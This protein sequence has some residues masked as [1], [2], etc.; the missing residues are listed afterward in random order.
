MA[1]GEYE[2]IYSYITS[3]LESGKAELSWPDE[4]ST[5][6]EEG[7]YSLLLSNSEYSADCAKQLIKNLSQIKHSGRID[8]DLWKQIIETNSTVSV[9]LH[10]FLLTS[11]LEDPVSYSSID[12]EITE[13]I[14]RD[15]LFF[16][17]VKTKFT[18]TAILTIQ[19]TDL[20]HKLAELGNL[21]EALAIT[22]SIKELHKKDFELD[23]RQSVVQQN[24]GISEYRSQLSIIQ[25]KIDRL[26]DSN[27]GIIS[28]FGSAYIYRGYMVALID[29][30]VV[31]YKTHDVYE[32]RS[33]QGITSMLVTKETGFRTKGTFSLRVAKAAEIPM[34]LKE[35]F[36]GF[37]QSIPLLVEV[38]D[39]EW[40]D[41]LVHKKEHDELASQR[42]RLQ[43]LIDNAENSNESSVK[44]INSQRNEIAR[45]IN[46]LEKNLKAW[47]KANA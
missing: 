22:N 9:G 15:S 41:Y 10:K 45:E 36:G 17:F 31:K 20:I 25:G 29:E 43:R 27:N 28:D 13:V 24:S 46:K 40:S 44:A 8:N 14:K 5:S 7:L 18:R 16:P 3:E 19:K 38:T 32:V 12:N 23:Q 2:K 1:D 21:Q 26:L 35:S 42:R 4:E 6:F 37:K 33:F 39:K 34:T 47:A 11:Y 30:L